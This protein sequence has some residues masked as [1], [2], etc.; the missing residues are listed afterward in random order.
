[1]R[2]FT[3]SAR[4]QRHKRNWKKEEDT[5]QNAPRFF[6]NQKNT[7]IKYQLMIFRFLNFVNVFSAHAET[8]SEDYP[9]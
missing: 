1:M 7:K 5:K 3:T 4:H 2:S 9:K 8:S 6:E